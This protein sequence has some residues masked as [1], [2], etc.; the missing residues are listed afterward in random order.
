MK[1]RVTECYRN[2]WN[3]AN[4]KFENGCLMLGRWWSKRSKGRKE[5]SRMEKIYG[6][7]W[8]E[9]KSCKENSQRD[10][11]IAE[12]KRGRQK[13][14]MILMEIKACLG[15]GCR[16]LNKEPQTDLMELKIK[17]L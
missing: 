16:R 17:K 8:L 6:I 13:C 12:I 2:L 10:Q 3:Y 14:R 1:S 9:R 11:G 7:M 5:G 15:N 4:R